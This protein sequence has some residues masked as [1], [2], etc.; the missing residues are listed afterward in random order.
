MA[1]ILK[2]ITFTG[3]D[4]KTDIN[5]LYQIQKEF[6]IVEWGILVSKNWRENGNRYFNPSFLPALEHRRLNLSCHLCGSIA[7]SAIRQD[8][9]PLHNWLCRCGYTSM[10]NR[11]QINVGSEKDNP[12][13][14]R[15]TGDAMDFN[16][17]IIQQPSANDC[18][19][20]LRSIYAPNKNR[21]TTLLDASGGKG[22]ESQIEI[23]N[24]PH[25]I[26]YAGGI[27][28]DNVG[29][30]LEYLLSHISGEF[31]IDMES[32]VRT[33]DWFDIDKVYKVLEIYQSIRKDM[34]SL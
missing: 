3:V 20:F 23:L 32:G 11:C 8:W 7:R 4:A 28:A 18:G 17:I 34:V 24:L 12:S 10:F 29:E 1:T 9:K 26:G 27:S 13:C 5:A 16:E 22:L 30:K 14:F 31:W 15:Y 2:H 25:K 6:P 19:L 33:N 21:V